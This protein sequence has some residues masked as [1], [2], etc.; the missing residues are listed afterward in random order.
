MNFTAEQILKDDGTYKKAQVIDA[1]INPEN[2]DEKIVT[3]EFYYGIKEVVGIQENTTYTGYS[4]RETIKV[5]TPID[6]TVVESKIQ[7]LWDEKYAKLNT[8]V[9]DL[10]T[11]KEFIL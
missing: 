1:F 10:D 7:E 3:V 5:A 9:N 4:A 6:L 8:G 11:L 2:Y